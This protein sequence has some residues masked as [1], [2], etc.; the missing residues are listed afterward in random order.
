MKHRELRERVCEANREIARTGLAMLTWG[1]ASGADRAAGVMAIKPS[2][3]PYDRLTPEDV[4]VLALET[5]AVVDGAG[6]PSSDTPTHLELYRAFD[7]VG[8]ILHTHSHYATV[9]AQAGMEIPCLGATHADT[10]H[11]PVP[12]ARALSEAEVRGEYEANTGRAIIER[13]RAGGLDALHVPGVLAAGHAPFAWGA[14]P[15]AALEHAQILE[16]VARMAFHTRA[17]NPAGP[18][19]P[20]HVLEKHYLRKHGPNA[21]YGQPR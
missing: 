6:R 13:F 20:A 5:G 16:E 9:W 4:V 3:V 19:L 8:G 2:G 21:Y 10:F 11:G 14:T 15:E 7:G 18:L 17:L 12:L 1:N